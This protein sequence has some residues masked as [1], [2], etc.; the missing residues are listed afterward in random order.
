MPNTMT[1][2]RA[3]RLARSRRTHAKARVSGRPRLLVF[4]S[5]RGIYAHIVDDAQGKI[6]CGVSGLKTGKTGSEQAQAVGTEI[7]ALA[8]KSKVSTVTFDR[9]GYA[10]HGQVKALAE[11][12][13]SGGL[14]F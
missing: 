4:R 9:N 1:K 5:N 11:A 2:K 6:L 7:A 14:E 13:R 3:A 12:A 10:Y 8:K